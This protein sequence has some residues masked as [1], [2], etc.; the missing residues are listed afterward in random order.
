MSAP[1][2]QMP[3]EQPK[4]RGPGRPRIAGTEERAYRAVIEMFGQKGWNG[5]SLE[6]VAN[7]AGLGKSSIYLRWKDKRELLM[8]AV[9]TLET[10]YASPDPDLPVRD[11]LIAYGVARGELLLGEYGNAMAHLFAAA[12]AHPGEFAEMRLRG[13]DAGLLPVIARVDRAIAD[14]ELP[15]DLPRDQ[16]RDAIEGGV[17]FHLVIAPP[18]DSADDLRTT[19]P[20]YVTELV[21]MLLRGAGVKDA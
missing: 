5:I 15:A 13:V 12:F 14:G 7:H 2:P 11:Y 16:L 6:G 3:D 20:A 19:L 8:E 18:S 4:R 1:M 21:D 9:G 10:V 17:F